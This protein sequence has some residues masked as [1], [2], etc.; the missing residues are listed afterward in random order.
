MQF[1]GVVLHKTAWDMHFKTATELLFHDGKPLVSHRET[2][3]LSVRDGPFV[4]EITFE[5]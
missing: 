4:G 5:A 3:G 2:F 1:E